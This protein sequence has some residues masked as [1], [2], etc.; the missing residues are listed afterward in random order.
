MG[1]FP[2]VGKKTNVPKPTLAAMYTQ[3]AQSRRKAIPTGRQVTCHCTTRDT[4]S[5]GDEETRSVMLKGKVTKL[6]VFDGNLTT[7]EARFNH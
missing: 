3:G 2:W 1:V 6:S 7:D 5:P 4:R